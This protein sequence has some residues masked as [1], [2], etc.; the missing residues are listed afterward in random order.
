MRGDSTDPAV[1]LF[2]VDID[3]QV[4]VSFQKTTSMDFEHFQGPMYRWMYLHCSETE[5][6][7][8]Q[9]VTYDISLASVTHFARKLAEKDLLDAV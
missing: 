3:R 5:N 8:R 2:F 7:S 1:T 9:V 4:Q 6:C